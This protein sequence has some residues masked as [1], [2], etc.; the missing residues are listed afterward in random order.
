[1]NDGEMVLGM[2]GNREVLE[3]LERLSRRFQDMDEFVS[4]ELQRQRDKIALLEKEIVEIKW[5]KHMVKT[6]DSQ[7]NDLMNEN[8]DILSHLRK[9][10]A[11]EKALVIVRDEER[12][13]Y[14]LKEKEEEPRIGDLVVSRTNP[15]DF[16]KVLSNGFGLQVVGMND[17]K[18]YNRGDLV[19][20]FMSEWKVVARREDLK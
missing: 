18:M 16:R 13:G 4:K 15:T 17:I 10:E 9:L 11:K 2:W 5:V 1:V 20:D 6:L 12:G 14:V 8:V 3:R 7:V 19:K